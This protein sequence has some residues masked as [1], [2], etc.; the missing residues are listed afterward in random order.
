LP[1]TDGNPPLLIADVIGRF[2]S[3]QTLSNIGEE[4]FFW[5]ACIALEELSVELNGKNFVCDE[6]MNYNTMR[7]KPLKNNN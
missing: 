1:L 3:D 2:S 7:I 4:D 5:N 6:D